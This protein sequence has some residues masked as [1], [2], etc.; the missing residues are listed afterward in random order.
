[1][2]CGIAGRGLALL[3][4]EEP[5]RPLHARVAAANLASLAVLRRAG[6][7]VV[8]RGTGFAPGVGEEVEELHLLLG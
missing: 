8:G 3:L 6:F 1:V 5:V 7:Q 4:V 2:G